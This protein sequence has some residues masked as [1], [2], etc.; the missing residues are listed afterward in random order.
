VIGFGVGVAAIREASGD[1]C[2]VWLVLFC[3]VRFIE[4]CNSLCF[5]GIFGVH[6][7]ILS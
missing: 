5:M 6:L 1:G 2:G 3:T 7:R 4:C